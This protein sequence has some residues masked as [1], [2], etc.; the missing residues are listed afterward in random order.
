MG[1]CREKEIY[2]EDLLLRLWG[3]ASLQCVRQ[4]GG[5]ETDLRVC[6]ATNWQA[7][8]FSQAFLLQSVCR[9]PALWKPQPWLPWP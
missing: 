8:N 1:Y 4:A 2:F 7:G 6:K 3:L 5:L 9:I